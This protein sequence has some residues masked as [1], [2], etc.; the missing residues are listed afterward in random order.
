MSAESSE[1][2]RAWPA[3]PKFLFSGWHIYNMGNQQYIV[4]S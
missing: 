3:D 1:K 4:A 2:N